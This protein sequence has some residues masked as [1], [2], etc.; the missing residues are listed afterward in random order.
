M[1]KLHNLLGGLTEFTGSGYTHGHGLLGK[2]I[3]IEVN[4]GE[5]HQA[6]PEKSKGW[7]FHLSSLRWSHGEH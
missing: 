2:K 7:C 1:L 3:Q 4:Q 5:T 6:E